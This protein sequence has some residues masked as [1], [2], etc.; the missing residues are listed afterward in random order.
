MR[1]SLGSSFLLQGLILLGEQRR[2]R[3]TQGAGRATTIVEVL[4][5]KFEGKHG[6][7]EV[8]DLL[9]TSATLVCLLA[10]FR[11]GILKRLEGFDA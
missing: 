11:L 9:L 1:E 6:Q 5:P 10:S 2:T 8:L 7:N 3:I 4:A